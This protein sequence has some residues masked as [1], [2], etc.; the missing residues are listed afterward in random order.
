MHRFTDKA[1]LISSGLTVSVD[2]Q[3]LM[4]SQWIIGDCHT[5]L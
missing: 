3:H 1:L 5:H 4:F 2:Y